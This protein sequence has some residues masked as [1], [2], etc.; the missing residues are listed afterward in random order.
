MTLAKHKDYQVSSMARTYL[1]FKTDLFVL[2]QRDD[3]INKWFV[4][5]DCAGWFY[6][7][8]LL[9]DRIEPSREPI[10]EDWGWTFVVSVDGVKVWINVWAFFEIESCWLFGLEAKKHFFRRQSPE[11]SAAAKAVVSHALTTIVAA[12][13]RVF[14]HQWFPENPFDLGV[15]DF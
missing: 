11:V 4:G 1:L 2:R 13:Q 14:K 10:M 8:L 6:V 12:D 9:Q 5:G 3:D 7:R 15:K